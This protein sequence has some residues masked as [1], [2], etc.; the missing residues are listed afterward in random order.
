MRTVYSNRLIREGVITEE[1]VNELIA[2]RVRRYEDAQARAKE[3]VAQKEKKTTVAV[4]EE[5]DG[6]TV[7]ETPISADLIKTIGEKIALVPEG[8][9]INPKM[10]GQLAR[11]AKMGFGSG[12]NRLGIC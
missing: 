11:R 1:E 6:S 12:A 5:M 8:F 3:V 7:V 9:H 10:V 2:E 4:V